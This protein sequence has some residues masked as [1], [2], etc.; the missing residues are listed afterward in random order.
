MR[1]GLWILKVIQWAK[2][3]FQKSPCPNE[4]VAQLWALIHTSCFILHSVL[5]GS[6]HPTLQATLE[7]SK[8]NKSGVMK[9]TNKQ[10]KTKNKKHNTCL[11]VLI[12]SVFLMNDQRLSTKCGK[13]C[14]HGYYEGLVSSLTVWV[15]YPNHPTK[16][17]LNQ[18]CVYTDV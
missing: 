7:T 6:R 3:A 14:R 5:H 16:T 9:K 15:T 10:N 17:H 18:C 11:Y 2:Y 1:L 4:H 8:W 13:F 12:I